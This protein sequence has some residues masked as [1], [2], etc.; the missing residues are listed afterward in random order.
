MRR[1]IDTPVTP[2]L[3]PRQAGANLPHDS[4]LRHV[5][6]AAVYVDDMP[7]STTH[8]HVA[9][10]RCTAAFGRIE[11]VNLD[12]V[13]KSPGVVDVIVQSDIPGK[14]DIAP[15]F[16][17]DPLLAGDKIQFSGQALFAVVATS[18]AAAQRALT[19]AVVKELPQPSLQSVAV[20]A[21]A[22]DFVVPEH[23]IARGDL[24]AAFAAAPQTISGHIEIHGQEHFYLE[25]QVAEAH[26]TEEGVLVY[27]SSQ[28]PG[29]LQKLIAEVLALPMHKVVVEVRRMG[30]G[31]GGKETQA[32]LP[33]CLAALFARRTG[34]PVRCRLPRKDDMIITGK[35]HPFSND[36]KAAFDSEG[37]ILAAELTLA[38]DC[39]C[40]AD[41]SMGIV[42]RAVLHA[43][44]AYYLPTVSITGLPCRTNKVSNTAFRGFGAP[45][46]MLT[47]EAMLDDVARAVGRD[48]LDVRLTNLYKLGE[49]TPYGQAIEETVLPD[50]LEQL[51]TSADYRARRAAIA[52]FNESNSVLRKGLALT[53]VKF[54]ISFTTTHLNQAGAQVAIYT[55]GSIHLNHG[56]TEMGQG[57]FIKVAQVVASAFGVDIDRVMVTATRTDK[58][59]NASPTA[60]SAGTDLNGMA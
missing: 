19:K 58:V 5:R 20:A 39:G 41:L 47:T 35:R 1:L 32:A 12:E 42:D 45:Q 31:F 23:V 43:D 3:N 49:T 11:S 38:A 54:G 10:G 53:P 25:G 6:G 28:H 24:A 59:P 4:A 17:G 30:G 36:Y 44:N 14:V 29:E 13:R 34:K 51:A 56:G 33:A 18:F 26:C 7:L 40:S 37:R 16:D 8:L 50:L 57:L 21:A 27:S 48:P 46:G 22:R 2:A 55:D 9:I 60:A 52:S 15:V